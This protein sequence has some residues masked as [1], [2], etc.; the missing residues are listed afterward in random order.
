[1]CKIYSHVPSKK[2]G[3]QRKLRQTKF[4]WQNWPNA[5]FCLSF[6]LWQGFWRPEQEEIICTYS[7]PLII[8]NCQRSHVPQKIIWRKHFLKHKY[9]FLGDSSYYFDGTT[10]LS[11]MNLRN[12]P[13][14][15]WL[16]NVKYL[17]CSKKIENL[18]RLVCRKSEMYTLSG[19]FQS[20][21]S[22]IVSSPGQLC[23]P[24]L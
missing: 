2:T 19:L 9:V 20:H 10:L 23:P 3:H 21:C 24:P 6:L 17:I 22:L 12:S 18:T 5:K 15:A 4:E 13:K 7:R 14:V 11:N 1:M 16:Q 8:Q